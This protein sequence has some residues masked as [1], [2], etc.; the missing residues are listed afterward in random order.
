MLGT[1]L[2]LGGP[3]GISAAAISAGNGV[4]ATG[5]RAAVFGSKEEFACRLG[6]GRVAWAESHR[7][8]LVAMELGRS[9]PLF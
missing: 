9:C 2:E 6:C 3:G 8:S 4:E 7:F 5:E 1:L